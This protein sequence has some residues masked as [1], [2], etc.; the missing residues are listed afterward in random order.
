M[1][2]ESFYGQEEFMEIEI[3]F[4]QI[5]KNSVNLDSKANRLME[6]LEKNGLSSQNIPVVYI[7]MKVV[8][9]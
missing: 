3:G 2:L 4:N 1:E 9:E 5:K 6:I 7:G 8:E